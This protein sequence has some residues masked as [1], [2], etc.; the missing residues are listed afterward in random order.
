MQARL[1]RVTFGL[2]V[3]NGEPFVR[4]NLRALYPFAHQIIVVEGAVSDAAQLAGP[5]GHSSDGT[6]DTLNRFRLEEDPDDKLEIVTNDGLWSRAEDQVRAFTR[7]ATGDYLWMV[8]IDEFYRAED[9]RAVLRLLKSDADITA[10]FF[11]QITFWG[12]FDYVADGWYLRQRQGE[13]PGVVLRLV[14]WEDGYDYASHR[15]VT[16]RDQDGKDLVKGKTLGGEELAAEDRFMYHYSLVFPRHVR[17]K[18]EHYSRADWANASRIGLWAEKAYRQLRWPYRVHN[19]YRYPSWL[20]RFEGRHP[21]Q[22]EI[23]RADLA[24]GRVSEER[25]ATDDIEALL[26]SYWYRAGRAVLRG[27]DPLARF[28]I[29]LRRRMNPIRKRPSAENRRVP[30]IT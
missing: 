2:R 22:I 18:A 21:E 12:G 28:A 8:D 19:V 20:S 16:I 1:P 26:D 30:E 24:S 10:V 29:R 7:R 6:L 15:P 13:G 17:E 25:R 4:Y 3:F 23:L 14:K 9:M 5:E 27:L 11:K